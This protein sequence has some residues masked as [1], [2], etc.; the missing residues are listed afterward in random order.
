[1]RENLRAVRLRVG[2]NVRR[3]RRLRGLTQEELAEG[4]GNTWKHIGQ[5]E[6]GEV[7]VGLDILARI[8]AALSLD[9]SAL[10]VEPAG[11][12]RAKIRMYVASDREL[13][14]I[15]Q[16]VRRI[17]STGSRSTRPAD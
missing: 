16:M 6:R 2:R 4:V 14:Q 5:V 3:L 13:D 1:M 9:V 7:N 12:R 8:A 15:D 10:F 17:R 11:R